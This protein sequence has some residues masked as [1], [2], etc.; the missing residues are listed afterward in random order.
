MVAPPAPP[1]PSGSARPEPALGETIGTI[2]GDSDKKPAGRLHPQVIQRAV[3]EHYGVFRKCYEAAL[4]RNR[5][6]KGRVS[7]RFVIDRDGNVSNGGSNLPD[8]ETISCVLRAFYDI[9]F[10]K[11]EGGIV[12]V[13]YPIM[14]EPG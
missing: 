10:P 13:V 8:E 2:D 7:A 4:A 3:R 1:M 9:R 12:T 11:P 6:L 5:E 14:L